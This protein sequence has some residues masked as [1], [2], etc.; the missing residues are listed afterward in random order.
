MI[1]DSL[2]NYYESLSALGGKVPPKGMEL[3]ELE[4]IVVISNVG[5]F[6]RFE[7]Q[8]IDKR[9]C[10][11]FMVPKAVQRTS[12]PKPNTLW[13]NGKYVL[14]LG[15]KDAKAHEMFVDRVDEIFMSHPDD[16]S[17]YALSRFYKK[18][19]SHHLPSMSKDPLY[20][21]VMESLASNFSFRMEGDDTIIAEKIHL[22]N[23]IG[24]E[25]SGQ[26]IRGIC[27]VTGKEKKLA[28]TF[29]PTPI[30]DNSPMASLVSFQVNSGYDSYGNTQAYNASVSVEAENSITAALKKLLS[31]DS[32]NKIRIGNRMYLFWGDT[33]DDTTKDMEEALSFLLDV[34]VTKKKDPD[35]NANEVKKVFDSIFS[36]KIRTSEENMFHILGLAPNTGR[37]AVVLWIECSLHEFASK[38]HDHF[39]DLEIIDIRKPDKR[40][41]YYGVYSMVSSATQ[42]GKLSDA[43]PNLVDETVSSVLYGIP[44]PFRLYT[45]V[46]ERIRAELH[47][48]GVTVGRASILK[49]YLNRK[50]RNSN[51]T[52]K[53]M[54]DKNNSNPGYLCG[55]LAAVL[56]KIQK[57]SGRGDNM[58]TQYMGAASSSPGSVFPVMLNVSIHHS[59]NLTEGS[60]IFYEQLKQEII[61]KMPVSGFPAHLDLNDQGR[62]FV[63]YYHQRADL[64]TSKDNK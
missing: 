27:M 59:E 3:K 29:T 64:Y 31:K 24:D 2:Y 55:R 7:S 25:G 28:R 17:I 21:N 23:D 56:E 11:S 8:R 39:K 40:Q 22:V 54:L 32:R 18:S 35:E 19:I 46:L 57:D 63:G 16:N 61:D 36:G 38:I 45:S 5:D 30:P 6:V 12:A 43:L 1:L 14:G 48:A 41:P 9:R 26:D 50:N 10:K 60:R 42:G 33:E 49:G 13:D 37:I 47:D 20:E 62:F 53:V 4:F 15:K 52:L 58:R 44:Y 51:N 34:S